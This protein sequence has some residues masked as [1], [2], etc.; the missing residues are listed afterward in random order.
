MEKITFT[1]YFPNKESFEEILK[2]KKIKFETNA[3]AF[4][5]WYK[6]DESYKDEV[7]SIIERWKFQEGMKDEFKWNGWKSWGDGAADRA[8]LGRKDY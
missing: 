2:L 4:I 3:T 1:I 6:V 7:N 8:K 5:Q